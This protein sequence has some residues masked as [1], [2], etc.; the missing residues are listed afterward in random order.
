MC[1]VLKV[2]TLNLRIAF[3]FIEAKIVFV[4]KCTGIIPNLLPLHRLKKLKLQKI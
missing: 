2:N 4:A 3:Y 1:P